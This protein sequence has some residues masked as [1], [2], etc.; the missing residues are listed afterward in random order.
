MKL[1]THKIS[2]Q[3]VKQHLGKLLGSTLFKLKTGFKGRE[4]HYC[5]RILLKCA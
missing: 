4:H 5:G 3:A 2:H 1:Q